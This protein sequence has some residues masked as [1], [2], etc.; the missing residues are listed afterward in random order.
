MIVLQTFNV[1][2]RICTYIQMTNAI[3][4]NKN[5]G[6]PIFPNG[7][8]SDSTIPQCERKCD[9]IESCQ[10]FTYNFNLKKCWLKDLKVVGDEITDTNPTRTT[11]YQVECR[12]GKKMIKLS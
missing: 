7:V 2:S 3:K 10:S 8:Y 1:G 11:V 12:E 5:R 9:E 4:G 6:N